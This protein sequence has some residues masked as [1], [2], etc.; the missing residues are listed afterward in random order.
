M[1]A[2]FC[3]CIFGC[4]KCV[5]KQGGPLDQQRIVCAAV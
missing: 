2:F 5:S 3:A 4:K 1:G